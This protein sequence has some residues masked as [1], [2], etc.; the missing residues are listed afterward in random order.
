MSDY[1]NGDKDPEDQQLTPRF[2]TSL[3]DLEVTEGDPIRIQVRV[4]GRPPPDLYWYSNGS[5]LVQDYRHKI[6]VNE[7]GCHTLLITSANLADTGT[8]TCL[9]K[10]RSGEAVTQVGQLTITPDITD[11]ETALLTVCSAI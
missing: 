10:S 1:L 11:L 2:L 5:M 6:I 7:A 3:Y 9:A 4:G 8:L